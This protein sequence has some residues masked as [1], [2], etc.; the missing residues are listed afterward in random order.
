M[1]RKHDSVWGESLG[2]LS[3]E[4]HHIDIVPK[5]RPFMVRPYRAEPMAWQEIAKQIDQ[6]LPQDVIELVQCKRASPVALAVEA[7]GSW[8]FCTDYKKLNSI[9]SPR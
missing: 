7:D 9:T 4:Q 8:R 5:A 3:P 2:K 6:M 1:L